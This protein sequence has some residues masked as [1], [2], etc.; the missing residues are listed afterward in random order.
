MVD[1]RRIRREVDVSHRDPTPKDFVGKTIKRVD[2][3]AINL[4]RIFFTDGTA[5]AIEH[6][7]DGMV[8]CDVCVK[9]PKKARRS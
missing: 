8:V 4:W 1:G 5:I 7:R 9:P 6:E 3:R 2:V